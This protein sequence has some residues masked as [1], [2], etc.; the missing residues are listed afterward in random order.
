[1]HVHVSS[2]LEVTRELTPVLIALQR[3][4][5]RA[6]QPRDTG[7]R[8]LCLG[9][10]NTANVRAASASAASVAQHRGPRAS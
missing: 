10:C 7:D 3:G 8:V 9:V 1:M 5:Y 4:A 6:Q 2:Q